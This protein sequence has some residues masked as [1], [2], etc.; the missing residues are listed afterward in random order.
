M[1]TR[2]TTD[3]VAAALRMSPDRVR[4]L[5]KAG[6]LPAERLGPRGRWLFDP[7]AVERALQDAGQAEGAAAAGAR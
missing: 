2:L 7:A 4:N 5:A 1:T 6:V 3:E